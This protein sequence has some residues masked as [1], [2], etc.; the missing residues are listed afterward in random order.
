[1]KH[2]VHNKEKFWKGRFENDI[3]K[4]QRRKKQIIGEKPKIRAQILKDCILNPLD[5][6]EYHYIKRWFRKVVTPSGTFSL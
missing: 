4:K 3:R 1:M 6:E 2:R 5:L